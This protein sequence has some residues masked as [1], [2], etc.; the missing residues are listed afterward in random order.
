MC[1][2]GCSTKSESKMT[3]EHFTQPCSYCGEDIHLEWDN[4][5][6]RGDYVLIADWV[7]HPICWDTLL[8]EHPIPESTDAP[9]DDEL[10]DW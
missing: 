3:V 4:G 2:G 7:Y 9:H 10:G 1:A 6:K 5:L 8:T